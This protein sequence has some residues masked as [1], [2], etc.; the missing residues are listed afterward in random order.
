MTDWMALEAKHYFQTQKRLPVVLVRGE[1]TRVYDDGGREYLDFVTGIASVSLGHRH[2]VVVK[3]IEE[4][5]EALTHTSNYYYTIPQLKLAQLLCETTGLD[6][7]FFGNSGTEAIEGA[8]KLARKW[9]REKKGGAYE[10][11]VAEGAF[12]GRTLGALAA[13]SGERFRA[14]FAPLP[15][16]FRR[17]PFD[18]VEAI[19]EATTAGTA[20]VL[21]EPIQGEGGVNVPADDYLRGV[22]AWCDEAGLMLILDEVQTGVGRTGSLFAFQG[23]G[24][25]P[26][27]LTLGKGLGGGLPLSAFLARE[28]CAVFAVG[29]HGTT[30]GGNPLCT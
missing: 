14:A 20:A 4:Q 7:V 19:R 8:I 11:I 16:G 21:L 28:H 15:E 23:Y 18:D 9:G 1:G 12:H 13:T 17:V 10:I 3:A 2:P 27:V 25:R 30:F 24:A 6:R 5:A 22:R 26:D 29:E